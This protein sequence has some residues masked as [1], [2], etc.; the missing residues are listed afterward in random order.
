MAFDNLTDS[1]IEVGKPITKTLWRKIK[2]SLA[3]LD[4]RVDAVSSSNIIQIFNENIKDCNAGI[5]EIRSSLLTLAQFQAIHG[6]NWIMC[7]GS[8]TVGT[9]Y[10]TL[11]GN[12]SVP[13]ARGLFWRAA[14]AGRGIDSGRAV[15]SEQAEQMPSH[16]HSVNQTVYTAPGR[17]NTFDPDNP[18]YTNATETGSSTGSTGGTNNGGE[19]RPR[20]VATN[21]FIKVNH[22]NKTQYAIYQVKEPMLLSQVKMVLLTQNGHD[23]SNA[24][25]LAIDIRK[26]TSL[27]GVLTT[28]FSTP[29]SISTFANGTTV[30]GVI[31]PA[32]ASLA[33]GDWLVLDIT[34]VQNKQS[35]ILIDVNAVVV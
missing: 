11:T 10:Y 15:G 8:S 26:G 27:T 3:N 6:T 23:V 16:N 4:S 5:G 30:S 19:L 34:S 21:Y 25:V 17:V 14:D 29:P 35:Q 31:N 1:E 9:A 12:A 2:D 24:G 32:Q 13:D 33:V 28:V 7:N 18:F 20:N 22:D